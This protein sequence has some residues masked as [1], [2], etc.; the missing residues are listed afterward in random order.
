[1]KKIIMTSLMLSVVTFAQAQDTYFNDQ[2][3][4]NAGDVYGSARFV[5]MSGAM[6]A[7]GADIS[8][9]SWNPAGIGLMR[10]ND[11]SFTAG[12]IWDNTG[13]TNISKA[14][15]TLDQ[16]GG[17]YSMKCD[18]L[19]SVQFIN[20]GFNYQKKKNFNNAFLADNMNLAGLSQM[21]QLADMVNAGFDTN[22]NLAGMALDN[23]F[24]TKDET[25]GEYYNKFYGQNGLYTQHTWGSLN[26]FD[27][28]ISTNIND[29]A[30]L[31]FTLGF[32]NIRYRALYDYYEESHIPA[33]ATDPEKYG[34]YSLYNDQQI[35]GF[36][37]NFKLGAIVRP[38]EESPL[39]V[40]LAVETPTWYQMKSS[41]F[42]TLYD[43]VD[44]ASYK[45]VNPESYLEYSIRSPWKVRLGVGSTI[46]N[47]FAWDVDYEYANY[48][49]TKMG[50]PNEWIDDSHNSVFSNTWDE[51]M[52]IQTENNLK[53]T[54]NVRVGI[55]IKP[56]SNFAFRLGYNFATSAYKDN[57]SYDQYA[58]D[59]YAMNYS[60]K[61]S[62]MTLGNVNSLTMGMGYRWKY[63]YLDVAYKLNNQKAD[64]YAFYHP[65]NGDNSP[66]ALG[67]V[68]D[69]DLTR[70]QLTA[71]LGIKF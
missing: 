34:D 22:S 70:H 6:G 68:K 62:Y 45:P 43:N 25:S 32:E 23:K 55:E 27:F 57:C 24:L 21:T 42:A 36:G 41:T 66:N 19:G 35:D 7:L 18:G 16:L 10:K 59:S 33:T 58:L 49:A 65:I 54:H 9:M 61:T 52:N 63:A 14:H 47:F 11:I 44:K 17:V 1:M 71:T 50:Y 64:F 40:A 56:V 3:V 5:G 30:Y 13:V 38:F 20:V 51:S 53:G 26:A 31:G 67:S 4:N 48:S 29:R 37:V 46:S 39:R 69:V 60:T 12:A 28:N 2:L 15:G 8:T